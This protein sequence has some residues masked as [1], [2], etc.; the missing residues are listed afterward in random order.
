MHNTAAENPE[1]CQEHSVRDA[2]LAGDGNK[3]LVLGASGSGA[4]GGSTSAKPCEEIERQPVG[5]DGLR[6]ASADAVVEEDPA[7]IES[8]ARSG[9]QQFTSST[10]D[11]DCGTPV[12]AS[13]H[14]WARLTIVC[15][16]APVLSFGL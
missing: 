2:S 5:V 4:C 14:S 7:G 11:G 10:A 12:K 8:E 9:F 3:A 1:R 6:G 16:G 15:A 13:A